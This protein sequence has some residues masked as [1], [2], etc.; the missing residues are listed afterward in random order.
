MMADIVIQTKIITQ[1]KKRDL[2]FYSIVFK[3]VSDNEKL[4]RIYRTTDTFIETTL[5]NNNMNKDI[6]EVVKLYKIAM[7]K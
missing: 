3:R 4:V 7:S 5:H 6:I 2:P 1:L